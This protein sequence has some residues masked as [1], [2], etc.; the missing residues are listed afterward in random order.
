MR[1]RR[2]LVLEVIVAAFTLATAG[3]FAHASVHGQA[4][5]FEVVAR[6]ADAVGRRMFRDDCVTCHVAGTPGATAVPEAT[7]R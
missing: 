3:A 5:I 6:Q 2:V 4:P 1:L 7:T